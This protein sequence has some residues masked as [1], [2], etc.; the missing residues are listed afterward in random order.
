MIYRYIY[1]FFY[2]N[3]NAIN[4]DHRGNAGIGEVGELFRVDLLGN[5][6]I[7][8]CNHC[9]ILAFVMTLPQVMSSL[10]HT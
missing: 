4:V 5:N 3:V 9:T 7:V 2:C 6:A 8:T 10:N 1:F